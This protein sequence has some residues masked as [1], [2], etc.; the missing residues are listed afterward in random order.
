MSFAAQKWVMPLDCGSPVVK[1]VLIAL[2]YYADEDGLC[3][4]S[5]ET[6]AQNTGF[7]PRAV[8]GA[9]ASLRELG[10]ITCEKQRRSDGS[11]RSDNITLKIGAQPKRQDVPV[12]GRQQAGGAKQA[13]RGAKPAARGAGHEPSQ[14]HQ[15]NRHQSAGER[16][17][18]AKAVL[19]RPVEVEIIAGVGVV[20]TTEGFRLA[21]PVQP[22]RDVRQLLETEGVSLIQEMTGRTE[23]MAQKLV[24]HFMRMAYGEANVILA[25]LREAKARGELDP[26]MWVEDQLR[27]RTLKSRQAVP[28]PG[29][30]GRYSR[31]PRMSPAAQRIEELKVQVREAVATGALHVPS[32]T[33]DAVELL[34][35]AG[36]EHDEDG[37]GALDGGAGGAR[38]EDRGVAWAA[39]GGSRPSDA[40]LRTVGQ[41][42]HDSRASSA[43]RRRGAPGTAA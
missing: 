2:A 29:S 12:V 13:A 23:F 19:K 24:G 22:L 32:D 30:A 16:E 31:E 6:L 40:L 25:Y 17:R 36:P 9:I 4:P 33:P 37:G 1:C 43:L 35:L 5:Q 18:E 39:G 11:R 21:A 20:E 27:A 34:L 14:N 28:L 8:R 38:G 26:S 3:W 15:G 42:G 7:S 10:L 41:S